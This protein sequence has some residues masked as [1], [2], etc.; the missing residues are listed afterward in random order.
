MNNI[1]KM[2]TKNVDKK[3][4]KNKEDKLNNAN[5]INKDEKCE[6]K[7]EN[8][9]NEFPKDKKNKPNELKHF[10]AVTHFKNNIIYFNKR[11]FSLLFYM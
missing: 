2:S 4:D 5:E 6:I 7:K 8:C 3:T 10:D 1:K 9:E 11:Q